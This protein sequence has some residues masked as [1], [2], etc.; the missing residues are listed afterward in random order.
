MTDAA[1]Q[2]ADAV[3][4]SVGRIIVHGAIVEIVIAL[5]HFLVAK[6]RSLISLI[7]IANK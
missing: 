2:L 6:F 1:I 3:D 5:S 7:A 4:L